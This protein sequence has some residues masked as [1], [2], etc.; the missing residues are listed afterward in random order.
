[1]RLTE[2]SGNRITMS[3][4]DDGKGLPDAPGRLNHY[5]LAIMNERARTL[6]GQLRLINRDQGGTEVRL[7]SPSNLET[8]A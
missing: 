4:M 7:S 2:T 5:G 8:P 3:V 1:M 6:D